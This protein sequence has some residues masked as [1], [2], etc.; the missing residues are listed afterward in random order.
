MLGNIL[1]LLKNFVKLFCCNLFFDKFNRDI[2][3]LEKVIVEGFFIGV[4]LI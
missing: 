2:V 3:L 1:F 4:G